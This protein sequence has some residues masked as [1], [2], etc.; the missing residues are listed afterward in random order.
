VKVLALDTA[1][2]TGFAFGDGT[3]RIESGY[4]DFPTP[5]GASPG[6]RFV[7]FNKWLED[8][9]C[10]T[11]PEVIVY[12]MS[13]QRGAGTE[14][15][16]GLTTRV[17]EA[18]ARHGIEYRSIHSGTLKKWATGNGAAKKEEMVER[19]RS[20]LIENGSPPP[21]DDNE[22]DAICML[23]W[24]LAGFPETAPKGRKK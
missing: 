3:S 6:I 7:M 8:L 16:A 15:L 11:Q 22:C 17:Q 18:A 2:R 13:H 14:F 23:A 5:R 19:A 1:T 4:Q 24:A 21:T 9:I 10:T 20:E 12:E